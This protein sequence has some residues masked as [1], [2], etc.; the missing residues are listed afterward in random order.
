[1]KRDDSS[2]QY[3]KCLVCFHF[4]IVTSLVILV[5]M[6]AMEINVTMVSKVTV[7][8]MANMVI[9][10]TKI[11][12]ANMATKVMIMASKVTMVTM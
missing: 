10:A 3:Y 6:S 4:L 8:A 12:M 1:M 7:V 2:R 9:I 5:N 11:N